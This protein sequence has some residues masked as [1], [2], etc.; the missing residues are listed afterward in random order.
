MRCRPRISAIVMTDRQR[1]RGEK[2]LRSILGQSV[3]KDM[4]V[5]LLDFAPATVRRL[6]SS[7]HPAVR[8]VRLNHAIGFGCA[9]ALAVRMARAPIVAFFE[10]HVAARPGW[11]KA[12]LRA[13]AGGWAGVG[14]EVHNLTSG[15]GLSDLIFLAGY[16]DWAPPL[17]A[18]ES[19]LIPGQNS[20]FK[21]DVLLRYGPELDRLLEA[22]TLLQWRMC[23]DGYR[24]YHAPEAK[25]EHASE[26]SLRTLMFGYYLVMRHFAPLRAELYHWPPLK[27][28]LRLILAPLGPFYRSARLLWGLASRRSSFFWKALAGI[29]AIIGAHLGGA[30]GEAVGLL[31][32]VPVHDRRFLIYEMNADRAG[33]SPGPR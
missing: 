14:P 18:G 33:S 23:A 7:H 12:I 10:E 13:H 25:I 21:R 8:L 2:C 22:D 28:A 20:T 24:L 15:Q 17:A 27:R 32:G 6:P 26:G 9:R 31:A 11:A 19:R 3:I 29:W 16:G 4:E 5:L 30:A 1:Q